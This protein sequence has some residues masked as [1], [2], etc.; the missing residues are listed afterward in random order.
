MKLT[1]PAILASSLVAAS[2]ATYSFFT[3]AQTTN[4]V[5]GLISASSFGA[6]AFNNSQFAVTPYSSI[7]IKDGASGTN[8]SI[9]TPTISGGTQSGASYQSI[10]TPG[11]T[12]LLYGNDSGSVTALAGTTNRLVKWGDAPA[13]VPSSIVDDGTNVN[14]TAIFN[15][16][17]GSTFGGGSLIKKMIVATNTVDAPLIGVGANSDIAVTVTGADQLNGAVLC[18]PAVGIEAGLVYNAW[19]S[20]TNTVTVRI[21]NAGLGAVDPAAVIMRTVVI[22]Y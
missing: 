9:V 21:L 17:L 2:A 19:I 10:K 4:V 16:N 8:W 1:V 12:G 15:A 22:N 13:V 14:S 18:T 5:N 6:S 3:P 11:L 20:A 7:T